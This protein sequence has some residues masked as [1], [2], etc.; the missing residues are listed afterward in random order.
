MLN[1][2]SARQGDVHA[3]LRL[4]QPLDGLSTSD[5]LVRKRRLLADLCRL[6]GNEVNGKHN[7]VHGAATTPGLS[8]RMEQT[9]RSLLGGDSEKQVAAKL[10]L[11]QHT[12]H[13]YVKALYRKYG[14]SSRGELLHY[15]GR[16]GPSPTG[17]LVRADRRATA[18][19]GG[20]GGDQ[21][22]RDRNHRGGNRAVCADSAGRFVHN[23]CRRR[24][25]RRGVLWGS[26]PTIQP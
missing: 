26:L 22:L 16:A 23:R 19:V 3:M 25:D 9:L 10:G 2:E 7:G 5:P 12:V 18:G 15:A 21:R 13:V 8:R 14:V 6:I 1:D 24:R 20:A 4:M 11:S 17:V